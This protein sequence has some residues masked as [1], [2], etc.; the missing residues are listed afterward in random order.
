MSCLHQK[1]H[2][3]VRYIPLPA[4]PDQDIFNNFVMRFKIILQRYKILNKNVYSPHAAFNVDF[5]GKLEVAS[6]LDVF[7]S[8]T[9]FALLGFSSIFYCSLAPLS[10]T[11]HLHFSWNLKNLNTCFIHKKDVVEWTIAHNALTDPDL[12]SRKLQLGTAPL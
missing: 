4:R 2:K 3:C 5:A 9:K 7:L 12:S 1:S 11:D 8:N 6:W 10:F